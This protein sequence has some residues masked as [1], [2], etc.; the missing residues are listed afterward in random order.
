MAAVTMAV[1]VVAVA[2]MMAAALTLGGFGGGCGV[3][4][5]ESS[6]G[7]MVLHLQASGSSIG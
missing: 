3:R 2:T 4:E 6:K 1:V 5:A 7:G